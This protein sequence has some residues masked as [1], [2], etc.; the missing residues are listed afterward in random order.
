MALATGLD[1]QYRLSVC[2][3]SAQLSVQCEMVSVVTFYVIVVCHAFSLL[4]DAKK[5]VPTLHLAER[6]GIPFQPVTMHQ[7]SEMSP[8]VSC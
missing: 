2:L 5:E 7:P 4:Q 3:S 6:E 1:I 8:L